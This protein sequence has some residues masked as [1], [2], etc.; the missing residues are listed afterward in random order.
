MKFAAVAVLLGFVLSA[1]AQAQVIR[2]GPGDVGS[3]FARRTGELKELGQMPISAFALTGAKVTV[4]RDII[5]T[6]PR[7]F[8][9]A[10]INLYKGT[11]ITSQAYFKSNKKVMCSLRIADQRF[12][13]LPLEKPVVLREGRQLYI[14]FSDDT[15]VAGL[16]QFA[17]ARSFIPLPDSGLSLECIKRRNLRRTTPI[18]LADLTEGFA[19]VL[20]IEVPNPAEI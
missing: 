19:G 18:T 10:E 12:I 9:S 17:I 15:P 20:T 11:P 8:E 14:S 2:M 3:N 1:Q 13:D 6:P 5:F 16:S 7:S 4:N